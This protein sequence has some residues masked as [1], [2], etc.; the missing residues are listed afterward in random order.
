MEMV[1][2]DLAVTLVS[3]PLLR[4]PMSA[5]TAI[6]RHV[7][8]MDVEDAGRWIVEAIKTR[9]PRIGPRLGDAW[10]AATMLLP[11]VTTEVSGRL[12]R[13]VGRRLQA[14]VRREDPA[15]DS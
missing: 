3:Y 12:F 2:R 15:S 1:G 10:G 14:R 11:R 13:M 4:T 9:R 6:Y 5:P 8:M 7:P